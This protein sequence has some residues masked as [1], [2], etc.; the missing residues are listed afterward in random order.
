[1]VTDDGKFS[2]DS[3]VLWLVEQARPYY[4]SVILILIYFE[5]YGLAAFYMIFGL[6][7]IWEVDEV[8]RIEEDLREET[9]YASQGAFHRVVNLEIMLDY[10]E[11]VVLDPSFSSYDPIFDDYFEYLDHVHGGA[12]DSFNLFTLNEVIE[13]TPFSGFDKQRLVKMD[14]KIETA[15]QYREFH[16]DVI[17]E[18]LMDFKV[19]ALSSSN[20]ATRALVK[21]RMKKLTELADKFEY[22][23]LVYKI[24][25]ESHNVV[26]LGL[27]LKMGLYP[28]SEYDFDV[29]VYS[30][31]NLII[32]TEFLYFYFCD[33][34]TRGTDDGSDT[35]II[36]DINTDDTN[37][38]D[39]SIDD[40][41]F[42]ETT[43]V[44]TISISDFEYHAKSD[45][46]NLL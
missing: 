6:S 30:D 41:N 31:A 2:Y 46:C 35:D 45:L 13:G 32:Y 22:D 38:D 18:K 28:I 36:V 21:A 25:V 44:D 15:T 37:T 27:Y 12:K 33:I 10:L 29:V 19:R 20:P 16:F 42:F 26:M 5:F 9:V 8:D 17:K 24:S 34:N 39:L 4:F 23:L 3:D 40:I 14:A 7:L 11:N 1:M 43:S